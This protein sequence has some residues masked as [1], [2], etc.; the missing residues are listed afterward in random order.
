MPEAFFHRVEPS[1]Y[2]VHHAVYQQERTDAD[3][4][5]A[6]RLEL[7]SDADAFYF[8]MEDARLLGGIAVKEGEACLPFRFAR[9]IDRVTYWRHV[10][11]WMRETNEGELVIREAPEADADVLTQFFHAEELWT[12][13]RMLRPTCI[14]RDEQSKHIRFSTPERGELHEIAELVYEAHAAGFTS[15][16]REYRLDEIRDALLRRF[17]A[18]EQTGTLG[19]SV[20]ARSVKGE[21]MGISMAGIYPGTAHRFSVIHQVSVRPRFQRQGVAQAMMKRSIDLAKGLGSPMIMLTVMVGN[22]AERVYTRLGFQ[23]LNAYSRMMI[24]PK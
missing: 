17:D 12:Q 21:A 4:D 6:E 10:I 14:M 9:A 11:R 22:P 5:W 15:T 13:R 1:D 20:L 2:A 24:P 16:R 8:L 19:M 7:S 3:F 18:F 23:P